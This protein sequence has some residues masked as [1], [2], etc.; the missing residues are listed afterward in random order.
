[1]TAVFLYRDRQ[2]IMKKQIQRIFLEFED[3]KAQQLQFEAIF[4]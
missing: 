2:F 4:W 1:M 3:A